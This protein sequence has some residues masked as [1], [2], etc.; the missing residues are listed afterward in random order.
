MNPAAPGAP[1]TAASEPFGLKVGPLRMR[2][3]VSPKHVSTLFFISFFAIASMN[4]IGVLQPYVLNV[5]LKIPQNEQGAVTANL[6][7]IQEVVALI[8]LAPIGAL[9]DRFGRRSLFATGYIFLAIGYCLY[10]LA[11]GRADLALFRLFLATGVSCVNAMLPSVANDYSVDST[12]AKVIAATFIFNGIGIATIPRLLGGLPSWFVA[13]GADPIWAG[14][15]AYWCLAGFCVLLA[16]VLLWG[17][18][19]GLPAKLEKREAFLPMLLAG[20]R[21][22]RNPRVALA[23]VAGMVSRADLGVVSTWL[24]LWLMTEGMAQGMAPEEALKRATFFYVI[25]Q[26]MALPWAPVWG[27][28]LDRVDRLKGLAAAMAVAV[29][30]YGSLGLLDNPL[31]PQMYIA[32]ACVAAGE[33]AANISAISLIGKEAPDRSRG[34]VIGLFSLFGAFGILIIAQVGGWLFDNWKP[35]GPFLFMAG[36]N[37][38][39]LVLTLATIV[40]TRAKAAAPAPA[41]G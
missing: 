5:I 29:L 34:A 31:G 25:I 41:A 23:Y 30:G 26:A 6:V 21:E 7:T 37:A 32:A 1:D 20:V 4:A 3:G 27:W 2:Q 40:W 36:A 22:G 8:L 14:R 28:I 12:R 11:D 13:Q 24:S 38:F 9:S 33:M 15:Y 35:V 10:P 18:K 16:L 39:M 17:L 19:P